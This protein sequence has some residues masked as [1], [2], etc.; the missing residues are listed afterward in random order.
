LFTEWETLD[1]RLDL[2][3]AAESMR[4]LSDSHAAQTLTERCQGPAR[5]TRV[6][7]RRI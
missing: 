3:E 4:L 7:E 6:L 5:C 2:T 1:E